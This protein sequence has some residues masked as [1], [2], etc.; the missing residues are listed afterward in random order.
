MHFAPRV[1]TSLLLCPALTFYIASPAAQAQQGPQINIVIIEGDGAINNIKQRTVREP[2]VE[3]QDE[4]HKPIAGAAVVFALPNSGPGA[5]FSQGARTATFVTDQNGR[6]VA[7]GL[8]TNRV[9]GKFQMRVTASSHGQ[10]AS[11]NITQTNTAGAVGTAVAAGISLKLILIIAGV[12]AAG[13]AGG[14]YA[15]TH[16]GGSAKPPTTITVGSPTLGNP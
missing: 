8:Q 12:A 5:T 13:V 10:T 15:G 7:R 6:V 9:S 14:V 1:A 11:T 2:I 16:S 4:N 3:V